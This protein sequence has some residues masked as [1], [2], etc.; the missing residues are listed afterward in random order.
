M[1]NTPPVLNT[2]PVSN[3]SQSTAIAGGNISSDG[4]SIII[5]RG[6]CWST[7]DLPTVADNKTSE[8]LGSGIFSIRILNL[9][10]NTKYYARAYAENSIGIGYGKTVSFSTLSESILVA[11]DVDGNVYSTIKIGEQIWMAEN[12]ETTRFNDGQSIPNVV[13]VAEWGRLVTPAY[14][15]SNNE[16]ANKDADGALYNWYAVNTGKLA[17]TGWHVPT[18]S[19]WEDLANY[20]GGEAVAGGKMKATTRW[21][22]PNV[23]ATNSSGF[24]AYGVDYRNYDGVVFWFPGSLTSFWSSTEFDAETATGTRLVA[25]NREFNVFDFGVKKTY[26]YCIRCIKD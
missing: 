16:P 11:V 18:K 6:I 23:G 7:N 10:P 13:G 15:W 9:I 12:L 22:S 26:G 5:A 8:E 1:M 24:T 20:L 25:D 21:L 3:I 19:E 17:P 2:L 4:G 14:C